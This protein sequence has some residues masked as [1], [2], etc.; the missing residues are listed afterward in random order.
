MAYTTIDKPTDYFNT[1][2]YTGNG[3]DN[4]SITGVNFQPDFVWIKPRNEARGNHLQDVIR[5]VNGALITNETSAEYTGLTTVIKSFDSDGF[6]LGTSNDVNKSSNT[7]VAWNWLA[8][9]SA[10][11]NTDGSI[12]SSVSANTT[13]GFSIVS[14]TGNST[15]GATV[16]HG[17][18]SVPNWIIVKDRDNTRSWTVYHQ[19]MGN[20]HGIYLNATSAKDD[21]SVYW[22]DTTP[23]S[24]VF[25]LGSSNE[26]NASASMI[27]YCFAEKK[28]YSKFGSYT[29]NGNADGPFVYTGFKP[30]FV[31]NKLTSG[32][33][34]WQI[35]DN[36]RNPFN[37]TNL[38]LKP[39]S[40]AAV[41]TNDA[42]DFLSNGFK[43]RTSAG[44]WNPS[45]GTF[46]YM[47]FAESPFVSSGG[48]PTTA[49]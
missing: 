9:G 38:Y 29:G 3:S 12:T 41:T 11:S 6:T 19:S 17:L 13:A 5:G 35:L 20:T 32:A 2:L 8:G 23:S 1:V 15:G 45:G 42:I 48:I 36:K 33:D 31:M 26:T 49:R 10:S 24:S 18:G 14:Y 28:G 22:N 25:T 47:A 39:N 27:A 34:D 30:A 43:L 4:H 16:G 37:V 44:S 46:I 7:H 21:D 40:S